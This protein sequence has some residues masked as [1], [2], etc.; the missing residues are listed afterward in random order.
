[1]GWI[2]SGSVKVCE[3]GKITKSPQYTFFFAGPAR[4]HSLPIYGV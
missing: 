1:M 4:I 3:V 2:V